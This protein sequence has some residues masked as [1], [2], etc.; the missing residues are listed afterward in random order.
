MSDFSTRQWVSAIQEFRK[1]HWQ[2][3][4]EEMWTNLT[5]QTA[6]LLSYEAVREAVGARETAQRDLREI[7]LAA[8]VGSVGRYTDF[9]RSFLPRVGEDER[10]WAGVW[11]KMETM[12]G[13]PPIEVYKIGAAYFVRDGNHRVS[14]ARQQGFSHVEAYVTEVATAVPLA[15]DVNPDNL[16]ITA[17]YARFLEKTQLAQSAPEV[18][19]TMSAAGNYRV[20][21]EQIWLHRRW[22]EPQSGTEVSYPEAAYRW[23]EDVYWPV[24]VFIRERGI[25]RD[26]PNRTETDLYVWLIKHQ[27]EL[28]AQLGWGVSAETAVLDLADKQAATPKQLIQRLGK[29]LSQALVPDALEAG[30]TVGEWRESW[31]STHRN[32]RLF[33]HILVALDGQDSGWHAFQQAARVAQREEGKLFGVHVVSTPEAQNSPAAQAVKAEF[34]R[35]CREA[36]VPGEISITTGPT[37]GTI[38]YRA[39]W[40]DLV[41]VSLSHPPGSQPVARLNSQFGQLLRRCSRPVLAVPRTPSGLDRVLLAYDGSPKAE[42]ALLVAA[43]LAGQWQAFLTVVVALE[44]QVTEETAERVRT[45]LDKQR[46]A[47]RYV[48]GE[49]KPAALILATARE[50]DCDLIVMGG[51]SRQP[52]L[53]IVVGSVVDEVLR[54]RSRPVLICR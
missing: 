26:F 42:E 12:E 30:P 47:A 1:A 5:G 40:A 29:K 9:T 4:L 33:S 19:L 23:L 8:I 24:V 14:V 54:T 17:R 48:V 16:I 34:G 32:D 11:S 43:Y 27:K 18:N 3:T 49:G 53:A 2:A 37:T 35:R 20:L 41:V 36:D 46:V 7:P 13:L 44:K 50:H 51:Y 28:S 25:L 22:L 21:E 52:V 6:G 15:P 39:R 31:L 45:V 38:C 10:R